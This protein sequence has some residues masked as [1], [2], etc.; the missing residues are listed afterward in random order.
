MNAQVRPGHR[1]EVEASAGRERIADELR[2]IQAAEITASVGRKCLLA[3]R[4]AGFDDLAI[5]QV[6]VTVDRVDEQHSRLGV[7]VGALH[8]LLPKIGGRQL[9]VHP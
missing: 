3:T 1:L 5:L 8:D 7:M 6:V 9:A 2:E 4:I